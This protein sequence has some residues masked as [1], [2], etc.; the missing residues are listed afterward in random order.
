M[1]NIKAYHVIYIQPGINPSKYET[2]TFEN[3]RI[4]FAYTKVFLSEPN[5]IRNALF[6]QVEQDDKLSLMGSMGRDLKF[7]PNTQ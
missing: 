3:D 7:I 4:A 6:Y 2:R 1:T 5:R